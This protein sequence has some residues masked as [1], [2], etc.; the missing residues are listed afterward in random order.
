[1]TARRHKAARSKLAK[2]LTDLSLNMQLY[3]AGGRNF[4][5][6][7]Y[8]SLEASPWSRNSEIPRSYFHLGADIVHHNGRLAFAAHRFA[9]RHIDA[10]VFLFDQHK[11]SLAVR[12]DAQQ[13]PETAMYEKIEGYC[14]P[15]A[16]DRHRGETKDIVDDLCKIPMDH[17]FWRDD[18]HQ[19]EPYEKLLARQIVD[20]ISDPSNRMPLEFY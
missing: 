20:H 6:I 19:T 1:M 12:R 8:A 15:Y 14:Y 7:N 10:N 16:E 4:L 13:F 3:N 11:M 17:W 9:E 5:F 2:A 18:A